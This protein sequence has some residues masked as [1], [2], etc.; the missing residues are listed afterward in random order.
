MIE[1]YHSSN[2]DLESLDNGTVRRYSTYMKEKYIYFGDTAMNI[3]R[4]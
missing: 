1:K 4:N 3:Q 2:E